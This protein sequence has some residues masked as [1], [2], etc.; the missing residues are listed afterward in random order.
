LTM[1]AGRPGRGFTLV[2]LLVAITVMASIAVLGWF[3]LDSIMRTRGAVVA[4]MNQARSMHLSFAQMQNDFG[5]VP[6]MSMI[7]GHARL[8]A[9][10]GRVV[11]V[12]TVHGENQP[13]Q[14]QVVAYRIRND[15]LTRYESAAT[16]DLKTLDAWWRA[17]AAGTDV[18]Q[19]VALQE[20]VVSMTLRAWSN[21]GAGWREANAATERVM[22]RDGNGWRP[23]GANDAAADTSG[24]TGLE[25][26]L[27]LARPDEKLT[28]IFLLGAV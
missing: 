7:G 18:R 20:G 16:R 25:V 2:E 19:E 28:K 4:Q 10:A 13:T 23:A 15:V 5:R 6:G 27:Q 22:I 9:D 8:L 1:R 11:L 14:F 3:G 21:D 24:P 12:R 26:V 17:V